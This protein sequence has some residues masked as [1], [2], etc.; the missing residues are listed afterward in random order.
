MTELPTSLHKLGVFFLSRYFGSYNQHIIE[1]T[2]I[3]ADCKLGYKINVPEEIY[4][5][6]LNTQASTFRPVL[7][8]CSYLCN[9][10]K[11]ELIHVYSFFFF[12]S[13]CCNYNKTIACVS[14]QSR[15]F[16]ISVISVLLLYASLY[17]TE[18]D[19]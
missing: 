14:L 5:L 12:E 2:Y 7:P 3:F 13:K 17:W 16:T 15:H 8:P 19:N 1:F 11:F 9:C 6:Y 4:L 18:P 10:K